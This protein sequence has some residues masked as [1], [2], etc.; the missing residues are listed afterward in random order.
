[1]VFLL[2]LGVSMP[3]LAASVGIEPGLYELTTVGTDTSLPSVT[4]SCFQS[5][6]AEGGFA[7]PDLSGGCR[8]WKD[9]VAGG[10]IDI[11][12]SCTGSGGVRS[13]ETVTGHYRPDGFVLRRRVEG[14]LGGSPREMVFTT[15]A[16]RIGASCPA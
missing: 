11:V 1:M 9:V 8:L 10:R 14:Q 5:V 7:R 15:T 4:R 13:T 16:R 3:A 6:L 12:T 2:L